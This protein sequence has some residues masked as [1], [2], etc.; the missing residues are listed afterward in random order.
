[1]R[2][3]VFVALLVTTLVACCTSFASAEN[4]VL[5]NDAGNEGRLLRSEAANPENAAKIAGGFLTKV[6]ES[7]AMTK[8]VNALKA[9]DGGEAAVRKAITSFATAKEAAKKS[10]A[11]LAKLSA[12]IA[13]SVKKDPTSWLRLNKFTKIM[14]GI[15]VGGLALYG[16]YRILTDNN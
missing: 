7:T 1:M 15:N 5:I 4:V 6:K 14:L 8:A 11:E 3:L 2:F 10:D 12:M 13:E 16:A 9:S